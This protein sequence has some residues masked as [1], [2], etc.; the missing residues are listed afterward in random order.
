MS[1]LGSSRK[2]ANTSCVYVHQRQ[3]AYLCCNNTRQGYARKRTLTSAGYFFCGG[4]PLS[5][6]HEASLFPPSQQVC[7]LQQRGMI[8]GDRNRAIHALTHIGFH[9]LRTYWVPFEVNDH[10]PVFVAGTQFERIID[11]YAFDQALRLLVL[12]CLERIEISFRSSFASCVA[13]HF[14]AH[15]HMHASNA[16]NAEAWHRLYV[17][18]EHDVKKSNEACIVNFREHCPEPVP[19]VWTSCEI[20]SF[21]TLAKWYNH[22]LPHRLVKS[23]ALRY[24]IPAKVLLSWLHH[25]NVVRNMAAHHSRLWNRRFT[26]TPRL[27][28]RSDLDMAFVPESRNIYNTL[29]ILQYLRTVIEPDHDWGHRVARSMRDYAIDPTLMGFPATWNGSAL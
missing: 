20:M 7:L 15:G 1:T 28:T 10:P 18:H 12:E 24:G 17:Q 19:P 21:G 8:I 26:F 16:R 4:V 22:V 27:R 2:A 23:I 25:L 11:L 9:R 14:G 5:A 13:T 3:P 29:V 6:P